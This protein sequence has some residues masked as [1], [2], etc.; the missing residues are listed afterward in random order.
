MRKHF[1]VVSVV[2]AALAG[3]LAVYGQRDTP[4]PTTKDA[5]A[6]MKL[7]LEH[8]QKLL[9]G[10]AVEDFGAVKQHA[11]KLG[12]L[13]LDENWQVLQTR[14]YRDYSAEFQKI[15]GRI[16]KAADKKSLDGAAVGYVQLALN[17]VDCHKHVRDH[18]NR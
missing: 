2:L 5:G 11:Q 12:A 16:S 15:T 7:K 1:L 17:C 18:G 14:E 13:A 4:A 10:L 3:S 6:F 9:E 8:T